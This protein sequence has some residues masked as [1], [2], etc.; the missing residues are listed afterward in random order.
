MGRRDDQIASLLKAEVQA[1]VAKGFADP[2]IRGL[3]TVTTV[4]LGEEGKTAVVRVSVLPEEREELTMHG[5]RAAAKHVRHEVSNRVA[6]RAMPQLRFEVDRG[7]KNQAAVY[8]ALAEEAASAS[9]EPDDAPEETSDE[10]SGGV[11]GTQP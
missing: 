7:L 1:V 3:I 4:D 11:W 5:L 2:R 6:L 8:R 10:R 9:A